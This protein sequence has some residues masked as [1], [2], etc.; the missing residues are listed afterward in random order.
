LFFRK[1]IQNIHNKNFFSELFNWE[2]LNEILQTSK[3]MN[4]QVMLIRQGKIDYIDANDITPQI[5]ILSGCPVKS[6]QSG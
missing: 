3:I 2:K 4:M 6:F 1:Q 5:I